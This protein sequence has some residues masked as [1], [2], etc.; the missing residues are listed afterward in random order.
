MRG[1]AL[2]VLVV[3]V[4][5]PVPS[6]GRVVWFWKLFLAERPPSLGLWPSE[7]LWKLVNKQPLRNPFLLQ[8]ARFGSCNRAGTVNAELAMRKRMQELVRFSR[9]RI[10][11]L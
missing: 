10:T 6:G 7:R 3:P 5:V 9:A 4:A 11:H 2:L 8:L 1:P